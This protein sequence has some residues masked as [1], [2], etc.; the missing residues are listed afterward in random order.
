VL[1]GEAQA[2]LGDVIVTA[3]AFL[4]RLALI[5]RQGAVVLFERRC[6]AGPALPLVRTEVLAVLPPV[7]ASQ[8]NEASGVADV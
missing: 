8:P 4:D 3:I 1:H 5:G 6:F 2:F 7:I